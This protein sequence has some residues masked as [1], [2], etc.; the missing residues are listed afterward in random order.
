MQHED[1]DREYLVIVN[2]EEQYSLWLKHKAIPDGWR[3][4]G[5]EGPKADCLQYVE[6]HWTDMR[7]RSLRLR[8]EKGTAAT[9]TRQ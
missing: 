1:D 4:T 5:C 6:T 7:P 3:S 9:G 8:M 2:D